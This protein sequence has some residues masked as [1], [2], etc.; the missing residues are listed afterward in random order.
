[1][2]YDKT[3]LSKKTLWL[4][5]RTE[6]C[7]FKIKKCLQELVIF[8]KPEITKWSVHLIHK[9]KSVYQ[10]N[11]FVSWN[12]HFCYQSWNQGQK[13]LTWFLLVKSAE[14]S[15]IHVTMEPTTIATTAITVKVNIHFNSTS[16]LPSFLATAGSLVV[17]GRWTDI[18]W[19]MQTVRTNSSLSHLNSF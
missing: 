6:S 5:N 18:L 12:N 14:A 8:S 4:P 1:M 7:F 15:F 10:I 11:C 13:Q 19:G 17:I 9:Y 2:F 16:R 3:N